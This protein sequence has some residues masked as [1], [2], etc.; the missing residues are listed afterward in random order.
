MSALLLWSACAQRPPALPSGLQAGTAALWVDSEYQI[1]LDD[2]VLQ[3]WS[4][5]ADSPTEPV[6]YGL[7]SKLA[8]ASSKP[9]WLSLPPETAFWGVRRVIGSA[10]EAGVG[11]I[12]LSASGGKDALPVL[13]PPRYEIAMGCDAPVPVR[14][15]DLLVTLSLQGGPEESWVIGSARFVPITEKGPTDGLPDE[16][17]LVPPCEELF[18]EGPER[19]ACAD[20]AQRAKSGEPSFPSRVT[21]GGERGCLLPI[22]KSPPEAEK[23]RS[24]LGRLVP[25]LGLSERKL[26]VIMPEAKVRLDALL[27]LMGA[28]AA[29][30]VTPALGTATLVEGNDGP[31]VC[32]ASI[33]SADALAEAAARWLGAHIRPEAIA[34]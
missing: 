12:F 11:P 13:S 31:P 28:F 23:W 29:S 20:Q 30:G 6:E 3:H 8:A 4:T 14:G 22:A 7:A 10:K 1:H 5:L 33:Q 27:P 17:L 18:P 19:A 9:L 25:V 21:F 2:Q 16:C 24:E 32:N 34:P 26:L 15:A